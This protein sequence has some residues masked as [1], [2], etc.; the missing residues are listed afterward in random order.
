MMETLVVKGLNIGDFERILLEASKSVL[1]I[2]SAIKD[3]NTF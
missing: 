1:T 3:F 2:A